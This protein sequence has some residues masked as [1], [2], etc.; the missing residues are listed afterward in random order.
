MYL[1]R[2]ELWKVCIYIFNFSHGQASIE[3]GFNTNKEVVVQAP[4]IID[5]TLIA[6][7]MVYDAIKNNQLDLADYQIPPK[8]KISTHGAC[9]RYKEDMEKSS[10]D[11]T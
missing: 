6:G 8:L 9:A 3:R 7:R 2:V 10:K 1:I 11:K 5:K 4:R